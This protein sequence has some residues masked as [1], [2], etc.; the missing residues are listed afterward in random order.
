MSGT[1][2]ARVIATG[3]KTVFGAVAS[4]L[5]SRAPETEFERGA[6]RFGMLVARTVVF[7]VLFVL[8]VNLALHRDP[9]ESFL[10][11]VALAV[12]L[13]PEFL[14]MITT[15]T[16]GRGAMRMARRKVIVKRLEAIQ[17]FG[18]IDVLCCD[19][20]G[21]LTGGEMRLAEHL[22]RSATV[23]SRA[24]SARLHAAAR[25]V[26]SVPTVG[27]RRLPVLRR[28]GQAQAD[29]TARLVSG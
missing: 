27:D 4:R 26:P 6:R 7:L 18:S 21:T 1:A 23:R 28:T 15:V 25:G 16:L 24:T 14:P 2:T 3:G 20:T 10:F 17:N 12:V 8:V 11:A 19:K 22:D 5:A 9:L 13:T 29:A